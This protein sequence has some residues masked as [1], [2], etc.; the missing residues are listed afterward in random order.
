MDMDKTNI[1]PLGTNLTDD[2]KLKQN[3]EMQKRHSSRNCSDN[4]LSDVSGNNPDERLR[5]EDLHHSNSMIVSSMNRQSI[6]YLKNCARY[7][8]KVEDN[9]IPQITQHAKTEPEKKTIGKQENNK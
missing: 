8:E 4:A 1:K 2:L 3:F 5:K 9:I 7:D 6:P